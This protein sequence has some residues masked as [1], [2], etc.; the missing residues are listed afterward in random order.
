[1][2]WAAN[3]YSDFLW[4]KMLYPCEGITFYFREIP[5]YHFSFRTWSTRVHYICMC[6]AIQTRVRFAPG[7]VRAIVPR[8]SHF[9]AFINTAHCYSLFVRNIVVCSGWD[10]ESE[11]KGVQCVD[12]GSRHGETS[13]ADQQV[14]CQGSSGIPC[15][16]PTLD[17]SKT[18]LHSVCVCI[19]AVYSTCTCVWLA[20]VNKL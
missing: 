8:V 11:V 12:A 6:D 3:V 7:C 19:L 1:M 13:R 16:H 18:G 17:S 15:P 2:D 10:I 5:R 20:V 4:N 14:L 9:S